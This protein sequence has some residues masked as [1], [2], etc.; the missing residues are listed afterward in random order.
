AL[1]R[2]TALVKAQ[3]DPADYELLGVT[4]LLFE[5]TKAASEAFAKGLALERERNPQSEL[6]GKLMQR[7]A[8]L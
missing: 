2:I 4:K 1:L 8:S 5:D 7:V 6:C 3:E